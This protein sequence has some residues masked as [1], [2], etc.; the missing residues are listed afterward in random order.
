MPFGQAGHLARPIVYLSE[1]CGVAPIEK[2][3]NEYWTIQVGCDVTTTNTCRMVSDTAT[4]RA[5]VKK[6]IIDV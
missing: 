1:G 5:P 3:A 6:G 4:P 2:I